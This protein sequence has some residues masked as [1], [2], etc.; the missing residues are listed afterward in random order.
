MKI[1]EYDPVTMYPTNQFKWVLNGDIKTLYQCFRNLGGKV[2]WRP[3]ET[4]LH[5]QFKKHEP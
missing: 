5:S 1:Q 2:E 3:V 4:V